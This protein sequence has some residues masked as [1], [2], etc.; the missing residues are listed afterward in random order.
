MV[1]NIL[2]CINFG[3]YNVM[4]MI[5]KFS[6]FV[7]FVKYYDGSFVIDFIKIDVIYMDFIKLLRDNNLYFLNGDYLEDKEVKFII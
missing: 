4:F 6:Q 2:F 1:E 3:Q 7:M 5:Q